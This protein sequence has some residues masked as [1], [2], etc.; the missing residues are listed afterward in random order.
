MTTQ[1]AGCVR[2]KIQ[3]SES[4][5]WTLPPASPS[6]ITRMLAHSQQHGATRSDGPGPR[7]RAPAHSHPPGTRCRHTCTPPPPE[8]QAPPDTHPPGKGTISST[9]HAVTSMETS[10]HCPRS[11]QTPSLGLFYRHPP[12]ETLAVRERAPRRSQNPC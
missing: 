8:E 1:Q 5:F 10:S 12:R 11:L 3:S 4:S 7:T 9:E 6:T 2:T